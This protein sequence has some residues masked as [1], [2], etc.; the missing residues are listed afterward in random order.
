[1]D[2]TDLRFYSKPYFL[3]L[4]LPK[5]VEETEDAQA[6]WL[7][8]ESSFWV[9]APKKNP[10]EFFPGLDMLTALLTPK[11]VNGKT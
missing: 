3:R 9:S 4:H 8:E 6:K 11:E 10:G 2:E 5:P 7:P 1:M